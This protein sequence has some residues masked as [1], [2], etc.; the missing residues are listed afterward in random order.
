MCKKEKKNIKTYKLEF[1]LTVFVEILYSSILENLRFPMTEKH[2]QLSAVWEKKK[3]FIT[4]VYDA[5]FNF[6][7]KKVKTITISDRWIDKAVHS[8]LRWSVY[9]STLKQEQLTN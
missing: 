3:L 7:F 8:L 9:A 6:Q 1:S 2:L 5:Q 4:I